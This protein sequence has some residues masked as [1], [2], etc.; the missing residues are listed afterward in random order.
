MSVC[1]AQRGYVNT[2]FFSPVACCFVYKAKDLSAPLVYYYPV[3]REFW[4]SLYLW[5][6]QWI[7]KGIAVTLGMVCPASDGRICL[8]AWTQRKHR[9]ERSHS[10]GA[11]RGHRQSVRERPS[12]RMSQAWFLVPSALYDG[13]TRSNLEWCVTRG[14]IGELVTD[15]LS[16]NSHALRPNNLA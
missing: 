2:F 1:G 11:P 16:V 10:P 12:A 6:M 15:D 8:V 5:E 4:A 9:R 13:W 14:W 3:R 7:T